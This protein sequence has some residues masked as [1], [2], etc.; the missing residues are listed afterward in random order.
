[1]YEYQLHINSDS[2]III[3][4]KGVISTEMTSFILGVK[5]TIEGANIKGFTETVPAYNSLLIIFEAAL[6][7]GDALLKQLAQLSKKAKPLAQTQP[8]HHTIPVCYHQS[9]A[10]DLESVAAHCSITV[11]QL[12]KM[13]SEPDYPVFMLG[14][15][16]GFLYLGELNPKLHCPRRDD[17][18]PKIEAGSV[19][20]GGS[21]TGLYPIDS[22][23]GWQIIG[24]TPKALFNPAQN[25]PSI[26]K[27][28]DVVR[29]KPISLKEFEQYEH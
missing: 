7:D 4:F 2:S 6:F 25:P 12:I 29:F 11:E 14:F 27:P 17:P 1:M 16:P 3:E 24:R 20:I 19:G 26:A 9:L 10:P 13:H 18:R 5:E 8:N 23:G 21:Q 22:P 15:L 28:L